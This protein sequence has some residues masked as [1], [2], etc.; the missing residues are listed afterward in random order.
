MRRKSS[1]LASPLAGKQVG[2]RSAGPGKYPPTLGSST[3]AQISYGS[4]FQSPPATQGAFPSPAI[5]AKTST[6]SADCLAA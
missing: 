1:S 2:W 3:C 4:A 6:Q 5:A